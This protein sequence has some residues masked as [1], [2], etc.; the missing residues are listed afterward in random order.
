M[1]RPPDY[2]IH[3]RHDTQ[4]QEF[5]HMCSQ[6]FTP[7]AVTREPLVKSAR[8][9]NRSRVAVAQPGGP[10]VLAPEL[11]ADVLGVVGFWET[12]KE[13]LFDVRIT[14]ADS[15]S[16]LSGTL[17]P[18]NSGFTRE[19]EERQVLGIMGAP[20]KIFHPPSIHN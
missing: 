19:G 7:K 6:G 11:R 14:D 10:V 13:T 12:G 1:S 3:L 4:S 15:P 16:Y 8:D 5:G 2:L 18:E 17:A 9:I 20:K